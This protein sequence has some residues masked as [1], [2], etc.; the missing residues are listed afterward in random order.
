MYP[1]CNLWIACPKGDSYS[2]YYNTV[3][4]TADVREDYQYDGAG[5]VSQVLRAESWFDGEG[6]AFAVQNG[7]NPNP[8]SYVEAPGAGVLTGVFGYDA[9]GRLA[10]QTDYG[11]DGAMVYSRTVQYDAA[12][13]V[14]IDD[15][16][17]RR[18]SDLLRSYSTSYYSAGESAAASVTTTN[19]KNG[20]T[21]GAPATRID[22]SYA[23]WDGAVQNQVRYDADTGSS[24]NPVYASSYKYDAFGRLT[25]ASVNDGRPRTV[26]YT[27]DAGGQV[28]RRD[29]ADN[30]A[31]GDPHELYYRLAGKQ[32]G[33][34]G[35]DGTA[36]VDYKASNGQRSATPGT[37]A[38]RG[39]AASGTGFAE[40]GNDY[41]A[42]NSYAQG[43]AG[44]LY[45]V[46]AGDSLQAIAMQ[47][48]GDAGL[49]YKLAEANG[50]P[51]GAASSGALAEGRTL[52][53][54]TGVSRS[55][56]NANTMKPYDPAEAL[57]DTSPTT[58]T[59]ASPRKNKCGVFGAILL[60][61]VAAPA[62]SA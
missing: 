31:N 5:R 26:T 47:L 41:D 9:M 36:N 43:S 7:M 39:G 62:I 59:P 58:P 8:Q 17:T 22:N 34:V 37:G 46:R 21:S 32:L 12:G 54:P 57:G 60:A 50:L 23:W 56:N 42:I 3:H 29:E 35:N 49:W 10:S 44:G 6:Y 16:T 2:G 52:A 33:Q 4:D 40:F 48:W 61:V 45:T 28:I 51:G 1:S 13:R 19:W 11:A 20:S 25:S 55:R 15:A 38:F 27:S 18:G 14:S 53:I 24:S 30:N